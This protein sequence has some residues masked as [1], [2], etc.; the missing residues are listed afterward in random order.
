MSSSLII[1]VNDT[2]TDI[3][4]NFDPPIE[5][6]KKCEMALISLETYYSFPNIS[7]NSN[8]FRYSKVTDDVEDKDVKWKRIKIP[9]GSCDIV[10]IYTLIKLMLK[11]EIIIMIAL[12][13]NIL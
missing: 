4:T 3:N 13:I 2:T 1:K 10:D 12:M 9:V 8:V 6:N 11:K 5:L 7:N